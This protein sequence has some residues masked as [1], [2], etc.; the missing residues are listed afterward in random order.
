LNQLS[1]PEGLP[2]PRGRGNLHQL[3][4]AG[5]L[6]MVVSFHESREYIDM[7]AGLIRIPRA[8]SWLLGAF[9]SEGGAVPLIDIEAWALQIQPRPW[10]APREQAG[11]TLAG[12]RSNL[13]GAGHLHALRMNDGNDAWAVRLSHSPS[14]VDLQDAQA[15]DVDFNLPLAVSAANGGLMPHASRALF[16]ADKTVA[17]QLRWASL[18]HAIRQELSGT[19]AAEERKK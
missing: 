9:G 11:G 14:V 10:A 19:S 18:A 13:H 7:V 17:L 12:S 16:F 8:P 1:L 2:A 5:G 4:T 6:R 15:V 3:A